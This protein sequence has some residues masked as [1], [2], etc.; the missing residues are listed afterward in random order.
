MSESR[1]QESARQ[2]PPFP[3]SEPT[4]RTPPA[5]T[6]DTVTVACNIPNGLILRVFREEDSYEASPGG[7]RPTKVMR[8]HGDQVIVN[9][10]AVNMDDMRR[11]RSPEHPVLHGYALTSGVSRDFWEQWLE[12]NKNAPYVT[13]HCIFAA[14][15]EQSARSKVKGEFPNMKSGLEPIDPDNPA[16]KSRELRR[17]RR[18]TGKNE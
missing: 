10:S 18:D 6:G 5:S 17:V 4:P 8:P 7:G 3:P 15:N 16:E 13:N 14:S 12:Q 1:R 9:G 11:G 2:T